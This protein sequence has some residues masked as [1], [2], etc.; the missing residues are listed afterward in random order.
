M[1]VTVLGIG[2]PM[3]IWATT[4]LVVRVPDC[5]PLLIDTCG[6]FEFPRQLNR[7]NIAIV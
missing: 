3:E 5:E 6:G 1:K 7:A 4:G 2:S